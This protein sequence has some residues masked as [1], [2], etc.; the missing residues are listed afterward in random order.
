MNSTLYLRWR[1]IA[2]GT[3]R[4]GKDCRVFDPETPR[5]NHFVAA[6]ERGIA[7]YVRA[8][9]IESVQYDDSGTWCLSRRFAAAEN[10]SSRLRRDTVVKRHDCCSGERTYLDERFHESFRSEGY[11]VMVVPPHWY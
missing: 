3:S 10:E 6:I 4:A 2:P 5:R 7:G 1:I 8:G 11:T 9:A